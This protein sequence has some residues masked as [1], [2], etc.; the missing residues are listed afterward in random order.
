MRPQGGSRR[1]RHRGKASRYAGSLL[2]SLAVTATALTLYY[3]NFLGERPTPGGAF[4][5]RLE[6][7][8]L[9]TRFLVRGA[10]RP[11]PRIVIVEIDQRSQETL[12]RWPFP[13]SHFAALL[14]ALREDGARVAVFDLTFSQPERAAEPLHVLRT[15]LA[16][17]GRRDATLEAELAA[18]EEKF[19]YDRQFAEAIERFPAVVLGNFFLYS[20][21]ELAALDAAT[22]QR[23]AELIAF[24]T[25]P[26]MRSADSAHPADAV[27]TFIEFSRD[28]DLLPR[29][30]EANLKILNDALSGP[31]KST[32]FFNV[33]PDQDGVIRRAPLVI[34]YSSSADGA[35]GDFY[36]SLDV[37][38]VSAFLG[39]PGQQLV[40]NLGRAGV[41]SIEF[42]PGR[43]FQPDELG[44]VNINYRGPART[45]P[46]ISLA[47]VVGKNFRA[48]TFTNK[49]VLVGA[50]ATGI[51]DLRTTPFGSLDHPGVEIHANIIDNLLNGRFLVRDQPQVLADLAAIL[52]F[53]LV[54]GVWLAW[55]EPRRMA[56]ALIL[57]GPFAVLVQMAFAGGHWLNFTVPAMFTLIPNV[58]FVALYRVLTEER[59]KRR[60]QNTFRQYLSPEVV[61]RLLENPALVEPRKTEIT[62]LF[63]DIRGYT[64]ISEKLDA[65]ELARLLNHYLTEMTRI[66]F[67]HGGTLDKYIGDALMAFWG[68]PF[69]DAAHARNACRA[70]VEMRD[71]LAALQ[72]EWRAEGLPAF[73]AGIGLHTGVASVGNMGSELRYGYTAMGDTV[74]LASRLE[75]LNRIYG[76]AVLLS[77]A[78]HTAADEETERKS[79]GDGLRFRE[80]DIVR[81]LGREQPVTLFEAIGTAVGDPKETDERL[82]LYARGR[83][84][85][86]EREWAGAR[87]C[88]LALLQRWP[89]DTAARTLLERCDEFLRCPPAADW[90]G[91]FVVVSK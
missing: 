91:V 36:P 9:D 65:Q 71:R 4:L 48:G 81:V 85:Y 53:G 30:V 79:S 13:R 87:E 39:L 5:R 29:G 8:T 27:R 61:R 54:T 77:A 1:V 74:N 70:G 60:V 67:R 20:E 24:H 88:F 23:Y 43:A 35:D 33:Y 2:I 31:G 18:L 64:R 46:Y 76:P 40:L 21:A 89:A 3:L 50:S 14:D 12:G 15:R 56:A 69:K 11:D 44:R 47:E 52:F 72:A 32:G 63:L 38:A 19:N 7:A 83:G 45:F 37:Q 57:L 34:S 51:G 82:A 86:R 68:A 75:G 28:A 41:E 90:D 62:V 49:I 25:F 59:E 78:T 58:F 22:R 66:V 84:Q 10:L 42:G 17:K 6:S 80:L 55:T 73:E 26:Q 16:E